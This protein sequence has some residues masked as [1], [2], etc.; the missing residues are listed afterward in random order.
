MY[1]LLLV[2]LFAVLKIIDD[3]LLVLMDFN[4]STNN[5][6]WTSQEKKHTMEDIIQRCRK[7][8]SRKG[9]HY[10]SY[11]CGTMEY[12]MSVQLRDFDTVV[13]ANVLQQL[14]K[15]SSYQI[16]FQKR[17]GVFRRRMYIFLNIEKEKC[18]CSSKTYELRPQPLFYDF[19]L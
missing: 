9:G 18:G 10:H 15:N 1:W 3:Y 14:E 16:L 8:H 11:D 17:V 19:N 13:I 2:P 6:V 5:I 12:I 7:E 4:L